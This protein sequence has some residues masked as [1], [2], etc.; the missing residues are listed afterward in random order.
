M[1]PRSVTIMWSVAAATLPTLAAQ[2]YLYG[3][4]VWLQLALLCATAVL[5]EALCLRWRGLPLAAVA[6]GSTLVAACVLAVALPPHAPWT[7][8]VWAAV[9]ALTLGKHCY[10]G[11]G[12]NPFNPAMLGYALAFFAFPEAFSAWTVDAV[13]SPTPL[14]AA[15][16]DSPANAAANA[17]LL[18][19]LAAA[20]GGLLLLLSRVADWRLPCAF[21]LGALVMHGGTDWQHLAQG[22]LVFAALFVVTDPVTA[23]AN[24][25]GRWL[26]G[27]LVGA[28][29][30]WLRRHGTHSDAIAFAILIG[31]MLAPLCDAVTSWRR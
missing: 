12:N 3:N 18:P 26:Y 23:P 28:L 31:N 24:R 30:V 20:G 15:R 25:R 14:A 21:A 8:A 10:G 9:A 16:L 19:A 5:T 6:D 7:V 4:A 22:G 13:S 29:C 2:A 11:L 27:F 1:P 17:S